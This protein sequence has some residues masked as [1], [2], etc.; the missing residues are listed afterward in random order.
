MTTPVITPNSPAPLERVEAQIV[1]LSSQMAGAM[2][3][4]LMLVGEF[5][6]AEGWRSWG[7]RS[8]AQWL[9]WK[10]GVGRTAG[11]EQVRVARAMRRFPAIVEP[12]AAGKLSY[13]KVR[14]ITRVATEE[15][16]EILVDWAQHS[17]A[18]DLERIVAAQRRVTRIVDVRERY[19]ARRLTYRWDDD[20]SLVGSFRLP[21]EEAAGFLQ[22]LEAA[23]QAMPEPV[24]EVVAAEDEAMQ[25]CVECRDVSAEAFCPDIS[26]VAKA[27]K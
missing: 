2:C 17:T 12:F 19:A 8:T 23:R 20:G 16:V 5:D 7:V 22:G 18:A 15:T 21:P 13:S 3:E 11:R 1:E 24:A 14:A 27:R 26:D 4:L 10:C 25:A 6:E 9:S